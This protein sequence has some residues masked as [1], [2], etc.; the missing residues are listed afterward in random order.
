MPSPIVVSESDVVNTFSNLEIELQ[1]IIR[2]Q[3]RRTPYKE[4]AARIALE[5]VTLV[6]TRFDNAPSLRHWWNQMQG[7]DLSNIPL[8]D[9]YDRLKDLG[10]DVEKVLRAVARVYKWLTSSLLI[11]DDTSAQK[12]GIWMQGISNVHVA[13]IKGGVMGHNLVTMMLANPVGVLFL[14]YE[15]KVNP[16]MPR[17]AR[18]KGRPIEEVRIARKKKKWEMALEMIRQARAQGHDASWVLFDCAY[19]NAGSE[20]PK[21]LT[22]DHVTFISK[23]KS[24]DTFVLEGLTLKAKEIQ[25]LCL[26]WKAVPR[27]DAQFYQLK[28]TLKD[29]T[30]V[31]LVATWFFRGRSLKKSRAVLVTNGVDI[32]GPVVVRTYLKRWQTERGYQDWKRALG[33][34]AYH[35]TDFHRMRNYIGIGFLAYALARRAKQLLGAKAN[36]GLPTLLAVRKRAVRSMLAARKLEAQHTETMIPTRL[37]E[38]QELETMNSRAA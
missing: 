15:V 20:V 9:L 1:A 23:A 30:E 26:S 36:V 11:I 8:N 4:E 16:S 34:M 3:L 10:V 7:D 18:H 33:G 13:N 28:V 29:G 12:Y 35:T 6:Q 31:K 17:L 27:T 22:K 21:R 38:P 19:F 24:N 32:S 2:R 14:K 25:D 5:I 37:S